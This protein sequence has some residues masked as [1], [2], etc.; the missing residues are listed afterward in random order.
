MFPQAFAEEAVIWP[1]VRRVLPDGG[2]LTVRNEQEHQEVN[3]L[4]VRLERTRPGDPERGAVFDRVAELLGTGARDEEDLVLPRLQEAV[5]APA[6]RRLGLAWEAVRRTAPTRP[7]PV[8]A[9]RPP[10][11][12]LAALP[13]S[14]LDRARDELDR[15]G[16]SVPQ[17]WAGGLDRTSRALG[18]VAGAVERVPPFTRGEDRRTHSGRTTG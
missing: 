16:R 1:A 8:V 13:L 17:P 9:R 18:A 4:G 10:G 3:E 14:V 6:L 5:G 11:N 2:E 7:H 15:A 12:A